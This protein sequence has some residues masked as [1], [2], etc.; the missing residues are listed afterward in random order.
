MAAYTKENAFKLF[1]FDVGILG[2]MSNLS[3]KTILDS[4]YG[5]YKG[6]F[7]ENYVAQEFLAVTQKQLYSWQEGLDEIEFLRE[8]DG[9]IIP[10]E[11]KSGI[12]TKAKSLK[13][14]AKKY[15]PPYSTIMSANNLFIDPVTQVHRYP[16]YLA[17]EFP[18]G[19]D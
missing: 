6:Y 10:I 2:A 4:N 11:V 12:V 8:I 1:L 18:M 5:T 3:P 17:G 14:F 15:S 16:L 9:V 19:Q 7:A 13:A